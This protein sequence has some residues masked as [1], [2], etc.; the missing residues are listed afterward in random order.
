MPDSI[1]HKLNSN[2]PKSKKHGEQCFSCNGKIQQRFILPSVNAHPYTDSVFSCIYR[3]YMITC[4]RIIMFDNDK[5]G[6][7]NDIKI[8]RYIIR[9]LAYA[10][11]GF[12]LGRQRKAQRKG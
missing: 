6:Y 1:D 7:V 5:K 4:S 3:Y 11:V 10:F 12:L 9:S 8:M 2:Y